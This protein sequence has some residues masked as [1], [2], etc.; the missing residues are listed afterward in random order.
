MGLIVLFGTIYVSFY[1]I[2]A[3]FYIFQLTF[4]FFN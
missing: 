3:H 2:L 1:I 4:T